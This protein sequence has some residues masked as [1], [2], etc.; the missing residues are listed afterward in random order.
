MS[1]MHCSFPWRVA[2]P[3]CFPSPLY[4]Y[5]RS[6]EPFFFSLPDQ[7][8][9]FGVLFSFPPRQSPMMFFIPRFLC[10]RPTSLMRTQIHGPVST[11][12][13]FPP[14]EVIRVSSFT[15]H[16]GRIIPVSPLCFSF[17]RPIRMGGCWPP[18]LENTRITLGVQPFFFLLNLQI[19]GSLPFFPA[20]SDAL[21]PRPTSIGFYSW[22]KWGYGQ[23]CMTS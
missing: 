10:T 19:P 21:P 4:V 11:T 22:W 2:P 9:D 8:N 16:R 1:W 14:P 5:P 12:F 23:L 18:H 7:V 20:V 17:F 3:P 15:Q 6:C 13:P